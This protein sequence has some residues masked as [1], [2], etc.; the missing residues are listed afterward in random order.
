MKVCFQWLMEFSEG[1]EDCLPLMLERVA[2]GKFMP[3]ICGSIGVVYGT[4]EI[5]WGKKVK[6][7]VEE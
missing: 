4:V 3:V 7:A 2:G 1:V 6:V 5:T